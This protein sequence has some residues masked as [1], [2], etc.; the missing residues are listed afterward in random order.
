M[1]EEVSRTN[2]GAIGAIAII[3]AIVVGLL[4]YY[5]TGLIAASIGLP[6]VIFGVYEAVSSYGKSREVD[7][8][9]TSEAY[10]SMLW[11]FAYIAVGGALFVYAYTHS[12]LIAVVFIL[13]VM[14]I[15]IALRAFGKN[16]V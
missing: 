16:K 7:Q 10:A 5:F 4:L 11:G 2:W 13:L 12:I 6:V 9:G 8:F 15:Y 3:L 1:S 14:A